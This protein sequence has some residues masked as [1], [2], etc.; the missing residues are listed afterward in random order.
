VRLPG[1]PWPSRPRCRGAAGR[2]AWISAWSSSGESP[3]RSGGS[4]G[5]PRPCRRA[6]CPRGRRRPGRWLARA[7]PRRPGAAGRRSTRRGRPWTRPAAAAFAARL[8]SYT[9]ALLRRRRRSPRCDRPGPDSS[10]SRSSYGRG[11]LLHAAAPA[12]MVEKL[13][14]ARGAAICCH[15]RAVPPSR[16]AP[17]RVEDDAA[18]AGLARERIER[19]HVAAVRR[20]GHRRPGTPASARRPRHCILCRVSYSA[21]ATSSGVSPAAVGLGSPTARRTTASRSPVS[22]KV[23]GHVVVADCRGV[24]DQ[25]RSAARRRARSA[26]CGSRSTTPC[27]WRPRSGPPIDPVVSTREHDRRP[28]GAPPGP[29]AAAGSGGPAPRHGWEQRGEA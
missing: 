11:D 8:R 15:A 3:R 9:R 24:S 17:D 18:V 21:A 7:P 5:L 28:H 20:A 25:G 1:E 4:A 26:G 13:A 23:T 16:A 19:R 22:A 2:G 6:S 14:V 27:A 29:G 12:R 10:A